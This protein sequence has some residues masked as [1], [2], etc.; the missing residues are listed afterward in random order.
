MD[1]HICN[2]RLAFTLQE[3]RYAT[4]HLVCL[5]ETRNGGGQKIAASPFPLSDM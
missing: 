1:T 4:V 2:R 3:L 5:I